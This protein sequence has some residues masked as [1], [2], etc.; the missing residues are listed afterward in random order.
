MLSK[1]N[2]LIFRREKLLEC[3]NSHWELPKDTEIGNTKT[4]NNNDVGD[5]NHYSIKKIISSISGLLSLLLAF[6]ISIG[7]YIFILGFIYCQPISIYYFIPM[8]I[9]VIVFILLIVLLNIERRRKYEY[10]I[11]YIPSPPYKTSVEYIKE[12]ENSISIMK[13]TNVNNRRIRKQKSFQHVNR[14]HNKKKYRK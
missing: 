1:Y 2:T 10:A 9:P 7:V 4:D 13:E 3:L 5:R 14:S 11:K 8:I 12:I 6:F